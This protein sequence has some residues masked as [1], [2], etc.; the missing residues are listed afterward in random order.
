MIAVPNMAVSFQRDSVQNAAQI[1]ARI[2]RL[3]F[4]RFHLKARI[5]VGTA[6]FFD[7]FDALAIAYVL[8]ALILLYELVFPLGLMAAAMTAWWVVPHWGWRAMFLIGTLPGVLFLPLRWMLPESP[9][10]LASRGRLE[11]ADRVV[12][13]IEAE[14]GSAAGVE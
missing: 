3:P 7:A 2:E 5:F 9:R 10:W 12:A 4:T 8:P 11:E 1:V 13:N 14:G 6:T